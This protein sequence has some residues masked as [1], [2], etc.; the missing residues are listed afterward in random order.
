M[1][2]NL[3]K[4]KPAYNSGLLQIGDAILSVNG[5]SLSGKTHEDAVQL[6]KSAGN[7]FQFKV[8]FIIGVPPPEEEKNEKEESEKSQG[9]ELEGLLSSSSHLL[10]NRSSDAT[11]RREQPQT[12]SPQNA[13]ATL[14]SDP[15][16][17]A[18]SS[19]TGT[20]VQTSS[21]KTSAGE[22]NEQT[23]AQRLLSAFYLT[24]TSPEQLPLS[25]SE[26]TDVVLFR[27]DHPEKTALSPS[28]SL[29]P[30]L[31]VS[32]VT[33]L[34]RVAGPSSAPDN[35][36]TVS[37]ST[38]SENEVGKPVAGRPVEDSAA[39]DAFHTES[40]NTYPPMFFAATNSTQ[41]NQAALATPPPEQTTAVAL[42]ATP[43]SAVT[44]IVTSITLPTESTV[45]DPSKPTA[46][47]ERIQRNSLYHMTLTAVPI[48]S[49]HIPPLYDGD[50]VPLF[51]I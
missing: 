31:N 25:Y 1:I 50:D 33:H 41:L 11:V 27:Y 26:D 46:P 44:P 34:L 42:T 32:S 37:H 39:S 12:D 13:T 15:R 49:M 14:P 35:R 8:A 2:S 29:L 21:M 6:L 19:E 7:T 16:T 24:P 43:T 23:T 10:S 38:P 5:H 51:S 30:R 36:H 3:E 45:G 47:K 28:A 9:E 48:Q 18:N 4:G 40:A 17:D 22:D 20:P